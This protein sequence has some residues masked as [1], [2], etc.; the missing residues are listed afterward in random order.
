MNNAAA[1]VRL[2][3]QHVGPLP[4]REDEI[5]HRLM[6]DPRMIGVWREVLK[7]DG[8]RERGRARYAFGIAMIREKWCREVAAFRK[9]ADRE[10]AAADQGFWITESDKIATAIELPDDDAIVYAMISVVWYSRDSRAILLRE[11]QKIW[12][13]WVRRRLLMEADPN[14]IRRERSMRLVT[15][16]CVA[17]AQAAC[18]LTNEKMP[19][20]VGT[21]CAVVHGKAPTR[22]AI[23]KMAKDIKPMKTPGKIIC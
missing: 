6:D 9:R 5:A 20:T 10:A 19:G 22:A 18:D 1:T 7:F 3:F 13:P 16:F 12:P 8:G 14:V 23:R 2:F 4:Q 17:V 11:S 21:L 15:G